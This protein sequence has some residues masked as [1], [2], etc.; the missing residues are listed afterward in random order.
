M[1]RGC[2]GTAW[3]CSAPFGSLRRFHTAI[4]PAAHCNMPNPIPPSVLVAAAE[5]EPGH[6]YFIANRQQTDQHQLGE[7]GAVHWY[8][9]W[10][11]GW[12]GQLGCR[13]VLGASMS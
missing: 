3:T 10:V 9:G 11:G 6:Y 1:V 7:G 4:R 8:C 2:M 13:A 5:A 12:G